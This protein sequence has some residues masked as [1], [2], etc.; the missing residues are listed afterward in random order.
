MFP[1]KKD[2]VF[3][4]DPDDSDEDADDGAN[5]NKVLFNLAM[6]QYNLFFKKSMKKQA[7]SM[8]DTRKVLEFKDMLR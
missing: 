1:S 4:K 2:R 8:I 3:E 7:I 5:Q 6:K